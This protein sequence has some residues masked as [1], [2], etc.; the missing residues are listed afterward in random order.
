VGV[1]GTVQANEAAAAFVLGATTIQ[2]PPPLVEYS[3]FTFAMLVALHVIG[4]P[5][6]TVHDSPPFGD[7][8]VTD[9]G[10]RM[11]KGAFPVSAREALEAS[12]MR[13]DPCAVGVLGMTQA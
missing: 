12:L 1:F 8:S 13:T 5:L 7:V 11:V 3:N 2:D 4:C 6:S 9:G 10:E